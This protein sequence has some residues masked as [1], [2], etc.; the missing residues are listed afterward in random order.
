M[1]AGSG[2]ATTAYFPAEEEG[3]R[4][5]TLKQD[6]CD[7]HFNAVG[8]VPELIGEFAYIHKSACPVHRAS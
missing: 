3:Q 8:Y 4:L 2:K 5:A 6:L 1:P 7:L